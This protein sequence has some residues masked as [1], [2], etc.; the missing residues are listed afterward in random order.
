MNSYSLHQL[1]KQK[2]E[3][4]NILD[5]NSSP[6]DTNHTNYQPSSQKFKNIISTNFILHRFSFDANRKAIDQADAT[7]SFMLL[8]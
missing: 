8:I 4:N 5:E 6:E 1:R 7:A 2:R 3:N